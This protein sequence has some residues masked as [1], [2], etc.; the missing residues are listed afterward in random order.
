MGLLDRFKGTPKR[1]AVTATVLRDEQLEYRIDAWW[2]GEWPGDRGD[3]PD[4]CP[5]CGRIGPGFRTCPRC[6]TEMKRK[7]KGTK[8]WFQEVAGESNYQA[9]LVRALAD[10]PR[11]EDGGVR[12]WVTAVL[13]PEPM[14]KYDKNAV[15]VQVPDSSGVAG[16][17]GYL[18]RED[19]AAYQKV[20]GRI[21]VEENE[22]VGCRGLV[23]GGFR[24][25]DGQMAS[26]GIKLVLPAAS[27]VFQEYKAAQAQG[28]CGQ[29][30]QE[31]SEGARFCPSCGASTGG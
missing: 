23:Q 10:A 24:M 5:G 2:S 20:L 22:V 17:V 19:A 30:G 31:L 21:L 11:R 3:H 29:C 15:Q 8:Y 1:S 13:V 14:N 4:A 25:D 27:K 28:S 12:E 9:D 16:V 18:P 26:Y 6:G 7:G